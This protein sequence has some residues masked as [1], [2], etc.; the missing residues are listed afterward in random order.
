MSVGMR[1]HNTVPIPGRIGIAFSTSSAR[2][3]RK[4][5]TAE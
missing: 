1:L 4:K 3:K 2:L 5:E